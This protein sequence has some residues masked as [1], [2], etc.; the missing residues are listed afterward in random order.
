MCELLCANFDKKVN[1]KLHLDAFK[2][3]AADNPHGFGLAWFE[4]ETAQIVK[5]PENAVESRLY[6]NMVKNDFVSA[7]I[8]M[9]HVRYSSVGASTLK[10][11][12]PFSR[13]LNGRNFIFMHNGTIDSYKKFNLNQFYPIGETDSE[14]IF[15]HILSK[16]NKN[17]LS[18]RDENEF[19]ALAELFAVINN[20]GN[21][22]CALSAGRKLFCYYDKNGY[23]GLCFAHYNDL[24]RNNIRFK[25]VDITAKYHDNENASGFIIASRP[26]SYCNWRPFKFGEMIV[27]E[28]GRAIYSNLRSIDSIN[29]YETYNDGPEFE[30]EQNILNLLKKEPGTIKSSD[31]KKEILKTN[32]NTY[33]K[34]PEFN[35]AFFKLLCDSKI[36]MKHAETNTPGGQKWHD[37][38][39]YFT[40]NNF[41]NSF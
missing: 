2:Y 30:L 12:H 29:K 1:L 10:N 9:A 28:N 18:M 24:S 25:Q 5:S 16:I 22:N 36:Y 15:C 40:I 6:D 27:F 32:N 11:C 39:T 41:K 35:Y 4:D 14:H 3:R 21:F 38:N 34:N 7:Q 8:L 13:E 37:D 17:N 33:I 20:E 19:K 31:I 23:N 26:F